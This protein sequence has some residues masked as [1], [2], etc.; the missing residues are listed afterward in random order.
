M[1]FQSIIQ[2]AEEVHR[3]SFGELTEVRYVEVINNPSGSSYPVC[4]SASSGGDPLA[5][6][7]F[8]ERVP[9]RK[10]KRKQTLYPV[11]GDS[12]EIVQNENQHPNL[13]IAKEPKKEPPE[14]QSIPLKKPKIE[15]PDP[16]IPQDLC[17]PS[18]SG[19]DG[20][21]FEM[22]AKVHLT[23]LKEEHDEQESP[24]LTVNG[25]KIVKTTQGRKKNKK[26]C[27]DSNKVCNGILTPKKEDQQDY[28]F[29]CPHCPKR[30]F[31]QFSTI[32]KH[33]T[34]YHGIE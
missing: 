28:G 6:E 5:N 14:I 4:S 24:S 8:I 25:T 26:I 32:Y 18:T 21:K 27:K 16:E 11:R 23:R 9:I 17:T 33:L 3:L 19:V 10:S 31:M 29:K 22:F 7:K 1:N 30:I 2:K 20:I 12:I 34:N 13:L 15:P